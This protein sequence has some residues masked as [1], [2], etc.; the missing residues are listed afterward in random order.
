[1]KKFDGDLTKWVT[2]W[3]LYNSSIHLNPSLSSADKF[4]YPVLLMEL[5]AAEAITGLTITS[6][7]YDEAISTLNK[8]FGNPQL[9]M[10]RH[11]E[12]RLGIA[13]VA[14]H[15]DIRA[16]YKLYDTVEAHVQGLRA[17]GTLDES[18][19]GLLTLVLVNK[20]PLEI[21][22][23]VNRVMSTG[24]WELDAVMKNLE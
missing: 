22:L 11:M 16:L 15:S 3:D 8:R 17:L 1:M 4:N 24:N 13:A 21:H 19:G 20:L 23:I 2:F 18:Y 5:S 10:N 12:A 6:A 14:L 9:I 7:N